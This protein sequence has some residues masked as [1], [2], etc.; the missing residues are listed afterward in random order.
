MR[1]LNWAEPLPKSIY[2]VNEFGIHGNIGDIAF[3]VIWK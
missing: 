1:K 3:T 2:V